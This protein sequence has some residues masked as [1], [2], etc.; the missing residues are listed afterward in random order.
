MDDIFISVGGC[1]VTPCPLQPLLENVAV[2]LSELAVQLT[3]IGAK[4]VA[5]ADIVPDEP[6]LDPAPVE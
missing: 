2:K 3:A 4:A 1:R 6:A 5:L